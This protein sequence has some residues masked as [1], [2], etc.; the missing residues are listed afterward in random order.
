MWEDVL[1]VIRD[2]LA[3]TGIHACDFELDPTAISWAT[4]ESGEKDQLL[5]AG[6]ECAWELGWRRG[7]G[8]EDQTCVYEDGWDVRDYWELREDD[9]FRQ[10]LRLLVVADERIEQAGV[11]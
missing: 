11:T 7:A 3:I 10:T 4:V 2:L 9:L 6:V 1:E 5:S 8:G